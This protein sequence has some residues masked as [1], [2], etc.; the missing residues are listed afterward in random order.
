MKSRVPY[1]F[2]IIDRNDRCKT[3]P[4]FLGNLGQG[5]SFCRFYPFSFSG[6]INCVFDNLV[7]NLTQKPVCLLLSAPYLSRN[8]LRERNFSH[9]DDKP[10]RQINRVG[11]HA[12]CKR[13]R[14]SA[15]FSHCTSFSHIS[16]LRHHIKSVNYNCYSNSN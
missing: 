12:F 1:P 6:C 5:A 11:E 7:I 3:S 2:F 10:E 13:K 4:S 9:V 16:R 15:Y 14:L 8:R